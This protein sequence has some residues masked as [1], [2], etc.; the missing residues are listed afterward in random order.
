MKVARRQILASTIALVAAGCSGGA[1]NPTPASTPPSPTPSPSPTP[2][3]SP[4]PSP[5]SL[6]PSYNTSPA[7]TDPTGMASTAVDIAA[8]IKLGVNIG[9]TLEAIGGETVWGNPMITQALVDKYKELGFDAIR[10]PCSWDFYSN[11][12]TAKID[13]AWLDR[14]KQVVQYCSTFR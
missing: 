10:L 14:V 4:T 12:T 7:P 2:A 1:A 13:A 5:A 11:A 6:Y 8:R 3:P 9:N